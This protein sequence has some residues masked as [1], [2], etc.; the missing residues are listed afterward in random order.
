MEAVG[1]ELRSLQMRR[2]ES[3]ERREWE[4]AGEREEYSVCE[5]SGLRTCKQDFLTSDANSVAGQSESHRLEKDAR[6][7]LTAYISRDIEIEREEREKR[8]QN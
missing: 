7:F 2:K 5:A 3:G 1:S 6:R 4:R 8:E